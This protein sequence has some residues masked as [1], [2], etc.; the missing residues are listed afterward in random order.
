[1]NIEAL[2]ILL[3]P[4]GFIASLAFGGR[5]L[6][7]WILS[8]KKKQSYVPKVFWYI[9]LIGN[10]SLMLHYCM[11][12]QYPFAIIQGVNV[13]I[14]WRN[15]NIMDDPSQWASLRKT[16]CY[17]FLAF[18]GI[19]LFFILQDYFFIENQAWMRI[20]TM[21]WKTTGRTGVSL[22][23]HL[24]GIGGAILFA[25][26]FWLQWWQIEKHKISYLSTSFWWTSVIGALLT[27]GYGIRI[28]DWV[29]IL[30]YG[31]GIIPYI[32]NL[33]LMKNYENI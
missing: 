33:M 18:S 13:V 27:L 4:T 26:R 10:F 20:P 29:I 7:Q 31:T 19:T 23:W 22:S 3:Y 25:S 1:M 32:R 30:G 17:L 14:S 8:E 11:Q 12:I 28:G 21:P 2:R 15:L 16:L 6:I 9:S 24:L 5:F